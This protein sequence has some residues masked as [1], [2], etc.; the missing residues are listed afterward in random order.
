M[1]LS[2]STMA[3]LQLLNFQL[4]LLAVRSSLDQWQELLDV[5]D[6]IGHLEAQLVGVVELIQ[7]SLDDVVAEL[8]LDQHLEVAVGQLDDLYPD[9]VVGDADRVDD[10]LELLRWEL[11]DAFLD[12]VV[13]VQILDQL[14]NVVVI[15][16]VVQ[17]VVHL[18]S[19]D[20]QIHLVAVGEA[21][22]D[23]LQAPGPVL[24][25]GDGEQMCVDL[26]NHQVFL[27]P[28]YN[29]AELVVQIIHR[30]K[31]LESGS[32]LIPTDAGVDRRSVIQRDVVVAT[33]RART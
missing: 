28:Q 15:H 5:G 13:P 8:V 6:Q 9:N 3:S 30:R 7:Q 11:V 18:E 25:D 14:H 26:L 12:H 4:H 29:V 1:W 27:L 19:L 21:V 31:R 17:R 32:E 23:L 10:E 22:D 2:S 33:S 20:D 16:H 24:V